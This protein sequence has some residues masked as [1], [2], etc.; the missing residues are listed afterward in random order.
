MVYKIQYYKR[1]SR[2]ELAEYR[3]FLMTAKSTNDWF[4]YLLEFLNG[5][6]YTG[7]TTDVDVH[8]F[9]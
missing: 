3:A 1:I 8:F 5:K 9:G 2:M 7:I 4:I 6:I